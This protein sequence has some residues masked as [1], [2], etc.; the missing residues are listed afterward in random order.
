MKSKATLIAILAVGILFCLATG[1]RTNKITTDTPT[2]TLINLDSVTQELVFIERIDTQVV[3]VDI[4][5]QSA[6]KVLRDSTS[7]LETDYAESDA[8][9]NDD[10]T[11][12]HSL[13]NKP[14][15]MP[16]ETY[17]SNK[18]MQ[19]T[20]ARIVYRDKPVPMPVK[21]ERNFSKWEKLRLDVFWPLIGILLA[22]IGWIFRTPL[23]NII[24]RCVCF[25]I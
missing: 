10:G 5:A 7:H 2:T 3:Y 19:I 17:V 20:N 15:K 25:Y 14:Q 13:K 8:W 24:R 4:P 21:I 22:S 18:E 23:I 9:L 6:L 12:G 1:C 11:L 16:I